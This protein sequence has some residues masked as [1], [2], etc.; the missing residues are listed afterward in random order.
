MLTEK[1]PLLRIISWEPVSLRQA[2]ATSGGLN[3]T[4]VSHV[5]TNTW[6]FPSKVHPTRKT[7][8]GSIR[9]ACRLAGSSRVTILDWGAA[10][11]T[12]G[13]RSGA[14]PRQFLLELSYDKKF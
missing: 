1:I 5:P 8:C 4:C 7:G 2:N 11:K 13:P 14:D 3:E 12:K 9:R 10:N 6:Q